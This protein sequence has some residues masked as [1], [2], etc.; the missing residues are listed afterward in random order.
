MVVV[1]SEAGLCFHILFGPGSLRSPNEVVDRNEAGHCFHL[2]FLAQVALRAP[3]EVALQCVAGHCYFF[4]FFFS[5]PS[6]FDPLRGTFRLRKFVFP[7]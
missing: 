4:L 1:G 5:P 2:V 6:A 3:P 7:N